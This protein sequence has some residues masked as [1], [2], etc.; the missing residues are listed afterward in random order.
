MEKDRVIL[1]QGGNNGWYEQA[2]F[3]VKKDANPALIPKDFVKEAEKIISSYMMNQS[4][5]KTPAQTPVKPI[6]KVKNKSMDMG[7]NIA[8][9]VCCVALAAIMAFGLLG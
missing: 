7:L 2:I 3:I 9:I 5:I 8:M 1:I 6:Y 4:P